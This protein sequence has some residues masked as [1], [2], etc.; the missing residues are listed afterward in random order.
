MTAVII[1]SGGPT[2]DKLLSDAVIEKHLVEFFATH[3]SIQ[4]SVWVC[5]RVYPLRSLAKLKVFFEASKLKVIGKQNTRAYV[6]VEEAF[7][8]IEN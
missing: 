7:G 5:V 6:S 8:Q 4:R 3:H 1:V 2:G